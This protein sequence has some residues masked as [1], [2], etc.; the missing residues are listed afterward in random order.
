MPKVTFAFEDGKQVTAEAR[1]E[2]NLLAI[3]KRTGVDV[4]A[5]C[6]GNGTCGKCRMRV[7]EGALHAEKSRHLTDEEF[8]DGWCLA[9]QSSVV[10]DVVIEVPKS[11]SAFKADIRTADLSDPKVRQAFD[12]VITGLAQAG[13]SG[14]PAVCSVNVTMDEPTL[15][16]TMPD[17]E[18]IKNAVS[19][20]CGKEAKL[21]FQALRKLAAVLREHDFSVRCI[22]EDM[23][24]SVRILDIF[25]PEDEYPVCG[26]AIDI[27]TTTVTAALADMESGKLLARASA[28]NGQIRYG[29]DVINRIIESVKDGGRQRLR[30][31]VVEETII[32]LIDELVHQSGVPLDRIFHVCCAGNTTMS[33][34]LLGLFSD[35]VR[36]EPFIP[37]FFDVE[38]MRAADVFPGLNPEAS[39][40]LAPNTGSYVGGDITAGVLAGRLW[41]S[42]EMT[43]FI[44]LGTNGEIVLGNN[45]YMFTCACSAGPAFEGG[46]ISCGMRAT[47]GAIQAI[48]ID[49]DTMVPTMDII[50]GEGQKPAGLCGS[51]IIDIVAELFRTGIIDSRGKMHRE[52][53][54]IRHDEYGMGSYVIAFA[55]ESASGRDVTIN[56]VDIDN[57]VRAKGAVFSATLLMLRQIGMEPDDLDHLLIAGGI[58]SGINFRNAVTIGMFPDIDEA[59]YSYIGN[60]SLAGAYAMVLSRTA[61]EKT[62]ELANNMTYVELSNEP[63]YMDEF[64]AA[65][66]LPHTDASLF[67]SVEVEYGK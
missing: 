56:E 49:V 13:I 65:C 24:D 58:G 60:S 33:H 20:A 26:L 23:G 44:D 43:L 67:P 1:F 22:L 28:G 27:G 10:E 9:C 21:S 54:R 38:E 55:N 15:D 37:S 6:N 62:E 31:A 51:G 18:R 3:A 16:D 40:I 34:L 2:D 46:E 61:E 50:G 59:K 41:D 5:P 7:A 32:P 57:F 45:E 35:P 8:E 39:L 52:G 19:A 47:N 12:D 11:A 17:N 66:F 64:I 42:E 4:D 14:R 29:A 30:K 36:M 48:K 63:G 25:G 53:E